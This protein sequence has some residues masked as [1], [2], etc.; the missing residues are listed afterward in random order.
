[1][2]IDARELSPDQVIS[3]DVC[4]VG[5]GPAGIS[6]ALEFAGQN[7][8]VCLLESGGLDV[9]QQA[10]NLSE[11]KT[12]GD[13]FL[14]PQLTRHR[15]FGGNSNIWAIKIG[16]QKMGVRYAPLDDID[17]EH[18]PE[19]PH[20]SG[21]PFPKAHLDPFYA[22]AQVVC[23]AGPYAYDAEAWESEG[24]ARLPFNPD[25]MV[26]G[27]FQFGARDVFCQEYRDKVKQSENIKTYVNATVIEIE[28]NDVVKTVTRVKV[29]S[30]AGR[31]FWVEAKLFVLAQGG[32]EN[33]RLLLL[34]NRQQNVGLG[35]QH[36]LVGRFFM[37]HPLVDAGM[38]VP[39]DPDLF[40]HMALY[41]L[42]RINNTPILG[43]LGLSQDLMRREGLLNN[44]VLLFPRPRL[45]QLE[46]IA[47]FKSLAESLLA[48]D[49]PADTIKRIFKII[50]GVDYVFLAG[51]LAAMRHQSLLHGFG[52]GGWAELPNNQRRFSSFQMF[53]QTEQ[54]PDPD[55][56][57]RL[58]SERDHLG[59]QK[60]E[61]HWRW[62]EINSRSVLRTQEL[63]AEEITRSGLGEFQLKRDRDGQ[64]DLCRPAG[65]AHHIGTTRMH[66]DPKQGVVDEN[67]RVHELSN[68]FMASSSV[69]PSSG[70]AN[71]TLTIVALS[72]RLA[73]HLKQTLKGDI[74]A[75]LIQVK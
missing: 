39:S 40:N 7:T 11:G 50:G 49:I 37:D 71:P 55:N 52:R 47:S 58:S 18:R 15:Q 22:K 27:M 5:S 31:Y 61:L 16:N 60:L 56:R 48:G 6:L 24:I 3:T 26:T 28:T 72:L 62:N 32:M 63:M 2:L 1:M 66:V 36:D 67:C 68:L 23:Q 51:F 13:P 17:F 57:I 29:A 25:Q 41:D 70:Y 54:A 59:C 14:S 4:I 9:N 12:I 21:W 64:P 30:S 46:A 65:V 38:F 8:Q 33:A 20:Y 74:A 53:F 44:A 42:R 75:P 35:N 19:I 10:Q 69:F 73:D 45:R 34:S 43:K